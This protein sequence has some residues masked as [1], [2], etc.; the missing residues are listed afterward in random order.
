MQD[1]ATA[2]FADPRIP[3]RETCVLRYAL[4]RFAREKPDETY[5]VFG[6]GESWSYR[7]TQKRTVA[8]AAQLQ[9]LGVRQGDHVAAW[10]PNG[11]E[12]LL[13]FFAVNYLG[14]VFVPINTA[15]R[16]SILEHVIA[17]S[18]AELLIVH[19]DLV[20]RLGEI[21]TAALTRL[22]VCGP[23]AKAPAGLALSRFETIEAG[24]LAP[25]D[26]PIDP[27]DTQTVV[28]TSGTTGPSKGVLMSYLHLFSNAGPETW[29]FVTGKDRFLVNMPIFHIG[30]VGL[31]FVMLARGGS[32][33]LWEN[34]RTD[35]FWNFVRETEC[36]AVFLLGVMA[37]FLLKEPASPRDREHKVR[38][39]LMVP[40]TESAGE[41]HTRFGIDVYTIF[42]MTEISSPIVS[43]PNPTALGSCGTVR[44]HVDVRLVDEN[45]CEV[46]TGTVGEMIVRTDRPWAMMHGYHKNPEATA[47]A[48]R[49][50]WFHTGDAF[51]RDEAGNFFFV[52]RIKDAIRRRGENISS[53]E[54][55]A[56]IVAYPDVQEA[57]AI[58]VP[59]DLGEDEVMAVVAPVAG[60]GIDPAAL[61][62]F[63]AERLPYFMVPRYIRIV[64]ELPKTPTA[65]V[66]KA[67]LRREGVTADTWD[68]E[69]ANI[70]F[71]REK[72]NL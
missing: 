62:A 11:A 31:P 1:E 71:K 65:K 14:A 46:P 21:G 39:A 12:A 22:V 40:L 41:F 68:R 32:I 47:R 50:G 36:T 43:E 55:E 52:D 16:G 4:D 15:Y 13:S 2:V 70:T 38:L 6:N 58:G 63:L 30:G 24:P 7:E 29:H 25:L 49:N 9:A 28:Y 20:P 56:E 66:Q 17:N 60:R 59:S 45:D 10:L 3:S 61:T 19:G 23:E 64:A 34:F 8:R 48:W 44:P 51:R 72:L 33:A 67:D 27:W 26:R 5:V 54:V 53:F 35:E 18:D 69:T 42:N 37:T 57:A